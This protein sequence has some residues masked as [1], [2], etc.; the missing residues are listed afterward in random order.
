[1]NR[2]VIVSDLDGTLLDPAGRVTDRTHA[3]VRAVTEDGHIFVVATGR[4]VRDVRPVAEALG[5]RSIAICGNGSI[6]YD[7][8]RDEVVDY[9]P[10]SREA[11]A[12]ALAEIRQV[13][14]EAAFGAER[15]LE[16][17]LEDGFDLDPA[18]CG[19]AVR[20][21]RLEDVLDDR[22]FGKLIVQAPGTAHDYY[23][24]LRERLP[25]SF[26]VTVSTAAFCEVT[27]AGVDKATALTRLV[28]RLGVEHW[29]TVAFGD[30]P[31]D[32]PMLAWAGTAV[33]VANAHPDVLAVVGQVT[34]AN[35]DDGVARHLERLT[36]TETPPPTKGRPSMDVALLGTRRGATH[37]RWLVGAP[38]LRLTAVACAGD[39]E[40]ARRLAAALAP[41][42]AVTDDAPGLLAAR[43]SGLVVVATPTDTHDELVEAA[44]ERGLGVLCE[45][46]LAP[47]AARA[48]KLAERAADSGAD[49]FV[50]FQWRENAAVRDLR[51]ALADRR[52][53]ELLTLEIDFH[54]DSQAGPAAASP[55]RERRELAGGGALA[56]LGT[57]AFDLLRFT[58][59]IPDWAVEW[60]WTEQLHSQRIGAGG[61]V[62]TDVD[63]LA[64]CWLRASATR[65][66]VAVSRISAGHRRL[67]LFAL[68]S[69]GSAR[70]V[71]DPSDGSAVLTFRGGSRT[72]QQTY[73]P[74]TMSPYPRLAGAPGARA[75]LATFEDGLAAAELVE[76]AVRSG[77]QHTDPTAG[78]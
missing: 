78:E 71:A 75:D 63:D 42:A 55:W 48:R 43:E 54:D 77:K 70:L 4:P 21:A 20:G 35:S 57:H 40:S 68:G 44:L 25:S 47:S 3:A 72:A 52:L 23:R 17:V 32:L 38:D 6:S 5:H 27:R 33:A 15:W 65:A 37:A 24:T 29:E 7:F 46:P 62:P 12:Q 69:L 45:A 36:V 14:P 64:Q 10:L 11:A 74:A 58:T 51:D 34:A 9:R 39:R 16:L 19:E 66:R 2:L 60:G 31:N 41:A 50:S 28:R 13:L 76:Q 22:G 73:A 26:E 61:P 53:G 8:A 1:M 30:M 49:A 56:E 67:E 18:L 59:G